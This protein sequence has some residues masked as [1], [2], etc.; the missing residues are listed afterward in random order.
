MNAPRRFHGPSQH[1]R[2]GEF[3]YQP[4]LGAHRCD[5]AEVGNDREWFGL[6]WSALFLYGSVRDNHGELYTLLRRPLAGGGGRERFFLQSTLGGETDLRIHRASRDSVRNAGFVRSVVDGTLHIGSSPTEQGNPFSVEITDTGFEWVEQEVMH[7]RGELV[8]PGLH[9]HLPHA[10]DGYYYAS[11]IYEVGGEILGREVRGFIGVDDVYMHGQIYQD[12]LLIGEQ[13]HISWYTW[14][15]RYTDG[16]LD[17]GHFMLGHN[18]F[19]FA[20][21][22]D[23]HGGVTRTSDVDGRVMLADGVWPERIEIEADGTA[24]EFLPD[25]RGRMVDFMPMPNPQIEGRWRRVGDIREPS[26]WFAF[27][28]V[29]PEHGL[30]LRG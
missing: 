26:H 21:L 18:G 27:G 20:L 28:E 2:R 16:S 3:P 7:L 12:D 9:W 4:V 1:P 11:Q 22:C 6:P 13:L 8:E 29:A 5:P 10:D 30:V 17:A 19:R 24:W 14:A 15:T 25:P 23:E